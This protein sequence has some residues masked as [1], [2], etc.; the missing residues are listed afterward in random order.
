MLAKDTSFGIKFNLIGANE[1]VKT[2]ALF[3]KSIFVL[4]EVAGVYGQVSGKIRQA[5]LKAC[6]KILFKRMRGEAAQL[7]F[8]IINPRLAS[9][10]LGGD[11]ELDADGIHVYER[12]IAAG[13]M[14][15]TKTLVIGIPILTRNIAQPYGVSVFLD[16]DFLISQRCEYFI[17]N[18]G[19]L[20]RMT[21]KRKKTCRR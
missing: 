21:T 2:Q 14:Q 13:K 20:K 7:P 18:Y 16:T 8:Q 15:W 17:T 5:A 4:G 9:Y 19:G 12:D 10:L 1:L 11:V 3:L 6:D